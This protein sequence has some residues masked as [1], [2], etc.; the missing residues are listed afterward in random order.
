MLRRPS[1]A[2]HAETRT[3]TVHGRKACIAGVAGSANAEYR[4]VGR[5]SEPADALIGPDVRDLRVRVRGRRCSGE[6]AEPR[7]WRTS[8]RCLRRPYAGKRV[9]G[10]TVGLMDFEVRMCCC[11]GVATISHVA[12]ELASHYRAA[13]DQPGSESPLG[14]IPAVVGAGYVIVQVVV[15]VVPPLFVGDHEAPTGGHMVLDDVRYDPAGNRNERLQ[16]GAENVDAD[17][18]VGG[19]VAA[20]VAPAVGVAHASEHREHQRPNR[21]ATYRRIPQ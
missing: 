19:D 12:D 20:V 5:E 21:P 9:D 7:R 17:V 2:L 3:R 8:S 4:A 11:F 13:L 6:F 16:F 18:E 1:L 10:R 15:P 14:R